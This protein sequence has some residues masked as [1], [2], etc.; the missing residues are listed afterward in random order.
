MNP[1]IRNQPTKV[2]FYTFDDTNVGFILEQ[3]IPPP[4]YFKVAQ[5]LA[6]LN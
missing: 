5:S 3:D 2:I 1:S 4:S 6:R